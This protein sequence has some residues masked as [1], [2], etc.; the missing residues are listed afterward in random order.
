MTGFININKAAGASSAKEVAV[1]KRLTHMPCGHMGTLD[2]MADGVLPVAVGNAA[3]LFDYFLQ[4]KKTYVATFRFGEDYDTLDTTG[5]VLSGGGRVPS[6]KE[7]LAVLPSLVGEVMQVPPKYS[8]KNVNGRRG[9]ELAREGVEFELP[10]KKVQIDGIKLLKRQ[11]GNEFVFEIECG[12]GTYIRSVARDMAEKLGTFAAMSALTR[13]KS[14]IFTIEDSVPTSEL[15]AE[16]VQK[17]LIPCDS[18]LPYESIYLQGRDAKK[19]INGVPLPCD[20]G[21][22]DYKLYYEQRN[23][24]GIAVVSGGILKVRT[25]LC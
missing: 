5:S 23:F 2:P 10:P 11:N 22:G 7:I 14:G 6:E 16:N 1:I 20:L 17:Y 3:R 4:K 18:V 8:A 13:T 15:T 12:G 25:K 21:D 19:V 24:Y 9:Y